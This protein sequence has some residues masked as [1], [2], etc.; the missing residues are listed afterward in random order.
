MSARWLANAPRPARLAVLASL[1][2]LASLAVLALA[3]LAL[4]AVTVG[5]LAGCGRPSGAANGDGGSGAAVLA[6]GAGIDSPPSEGATHVAEPTAIA[7]VANPPASGPHWPMWQEPWGAYPMELPRERWVHNLEH[8]GIVLLYNCP[9][10]CPDVVTALEGLRNQ[11]P[12]DVFMTQ[13][14]LITPDSAMPH[15]VAAVAW[16][17]RWQGESVDA[18]T[19]RCFIDARYDRAPESLP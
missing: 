9:E 11:T 8:G 19:L 13:R 18:A 17:W 6:C 12:P 5:A 15:R 14:L 2:R 4:L 1:A 3:V 7:Y 16:L 10:G